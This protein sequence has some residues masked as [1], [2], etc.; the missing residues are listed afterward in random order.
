MR[1]RA[2]KS[3][4]SPIAKTTPFANA[5]RPRLLPLGAIAA[6]FGLIS[7][8]AWAQTAPQS[9]PDQPVMVAVD[10]NR[11]DGVDAVLPGVSVTGKR[12]TDATSVRATTSTVGKGNQDI[13]DI[14]QS[15]TV[16]TEKVVDDLKLTNLKDA[17]HYTA[18][19]TFASAENGTDQDIRLRGF[20]L[21]TS[22]DVLIDGLRD[23]STYERDTFNYERIEVLRGSASMLFGRGSTGGVVNQVS[24]KPELIDQSDAI[25][26][27]GERGYWRTTVDL[28][29]RTGETSA[30][31]LN[32]MDSKSNNDG[33]KGDKHGIA[34]SYR[35]GIGTSDDVTLS[36]FY[37]NVNNVPQSTFRWL[38]NG[39]GTQGKVAPID[40]DRYYGTE[41]DFQKGKAQY[42]TVIH[43]HTFDDG[44][45]LK[46]QFRS[47][48]YDRQQWQTTAGVGPAPAANPALV[49]YSNID[50][51][52]VLTRNAPA[53]RKDRYVDSYFQS[54]YSNRVGWFGLKHEVLGGVDF[55]KEQ[56]KRFQNNA[57]TTPLS[58][59]P[60]TTVGDADNG[61]IL[62][63]S[64]RFRDSSAY[65][66]LAMGAYLQD[67]VS[68]TPWLKLLGGVR[69]DHFQGDFK[70]YTYSA[71]TGALTGTTLVSLSNSPW[72]YRGGVLLQPTPTASFHFSYGT[73]FNTSGDTYQF[74]TQQTANTDP[75]KSRNIEVGAKLD[76]LDDALSTRIAIFR[77]EKYNERTTD[78]DFASNA[79]LLSGK[80]HSDGIEL[81]I[82]GRI[83]RQ[84]EVYFSAS[85]IPTAVIDQ[86][87]SVQA[88]VVGQRVGLVPRFTGSI[89]ANYEF[90]SRFRVG[91]GVRG[92]SKNYPLQGTTGAAQ[93]TVVASGYAA[94]DLLAEYRITP[95]LFAQL[96]VT[97]LK[98]K[99]YGDQLYQGFYV[100][101]S[102]R[103]VQ[104]SLG[105]R[106]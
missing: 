43:V 67:L 40:P 91:V 64:P 5:H 103:L 58:A 97:N 30:F 39:P 55:A 3:V 85:Y 90:D 28:N 9:Q 79:F 57:F 15:V 93:S 69:Y 68:I 63:T 84:L 102:P 4:P 51:A 50:D 106:F 23:P 76:W 89:Y 29:K 25:G 35:F 33:P 99:T 62:P 101:G 18:G 88:A 70:N 81:D 7:G 98:N 96:N 71:A 47:G 74:V 95:D 22:G 42:G 16:L 37:L 75:E 105:S 72:S 8:A 34:P 77:T 86:I 59:R 94:I 2:Q 10:T 19:I 13:R 60:T 100:V 32:A 48:T 24:K 21:A 87:G 1:R 82:V 12:E 49:T 73:S 38:N 65:E 66:N 20:S 27:I 80:R 6:G 53:P 36:L 14:P 78:A 56:A 46:T 26:S 11:K 17:L 31:R 54:D 92:A 83:T 52:T 41:S 44:A 61:F 45:S 104:L